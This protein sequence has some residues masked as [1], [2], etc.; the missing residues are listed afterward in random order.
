[1][2]GVV[3]VVGVS[4]DFLKPRNPNSHQKASNNPIRQTTLLKLTKRAPTNLSGRGRQ[5]KFL[6]KGNCKIKI[7]ANLR[8][9]IFKTELKRKSSSRLKKIFLRSYLKIQLS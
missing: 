8:K 3:G 6:K 4:L 7:D 9:T 1:M 5:S 2:G